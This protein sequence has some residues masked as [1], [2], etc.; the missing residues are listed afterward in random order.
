MKKKTVKLIL[1]IIKDISNRKGAYGAQIDEDFIYFSDG[2]MIVRLS[3]SGEFI[4][5]PLEPMFVSGDDMARWYATAK[6]KDVFIPEAYDKEH[7]DLVTV[8]KSFDEVEEADRM[9]LDTNKF[10]KLSPL[11]NAM[12]RLQQAGQTKIARFNGKGWS[13]IVCGLMIN[14]EENYEV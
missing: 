10:K 3:K 5:E 11:G 1:D 14:K 7:S 12:I 2:Y 9:A 8:W 4:S 13:A 6:A